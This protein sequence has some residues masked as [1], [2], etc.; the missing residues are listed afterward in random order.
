ML[1]SQRFRQPE[2]SSKCLYLTVITTGNDEPRFSALNQRIPQLSLGFSSPLPLPR[3]AQY[4]QCFQGGRM[5]S[6]YINENEIFPPY[7]TTFHSIFAAFCTE[8]EFLGVFTN[9]LLLWKGVVLCP[10]FSTSC[11]ISVSPQ[12]T[13]SLG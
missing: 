9:Y 3:L 6:F 1:F 7:Y 5:P 11:T 4:I 12:I 10:F 13:L 8:H 2:V